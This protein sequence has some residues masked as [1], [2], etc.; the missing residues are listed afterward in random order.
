MKKDFS[1]P[2]FWLHN[3]ECQLWCSLS[4]EKEK[5]KERNEITE[6]SNVLKSTPTVQLLVLFT[7]Y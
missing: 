7:F 1:F 3:N 6:K 2:L 5:K 4:I